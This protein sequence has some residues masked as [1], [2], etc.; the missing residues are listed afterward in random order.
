MYLEMSGRGNGFAHD[1]P[2][3]RDM[4]LPKHMIPLGQEGYRTPTVED[5]EYHA[6]NCA[7]EGNDPN[8][9]SNCDPHAPLPNAHS[10]VSSRPR[11]NLSSLNVGYLIGEKLQWR[12]RI[13]HFTWTFFAMTMATGGIANVI[14]NGMT[15]KVLLGRI[16]GL[17]M[18]GGSSV[19]F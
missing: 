7:P 5:Y 15:Q 10:G 3:H 12:E 2:V 1:L 18:T 6:T 4:Y 8:S 16:R 17:L 11:H 14:S 9:K 13:R 19:S